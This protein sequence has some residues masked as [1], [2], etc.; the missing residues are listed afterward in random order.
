MLFLLNH[1]KNEL[2]LFFEYTPYRKCY[3]SCLII[4]VFSSDRRST[5]NIKVRSYFHI[6]LKLLHKVSECL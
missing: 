6:I 2:D 1:G 5:I 3:V 4:N